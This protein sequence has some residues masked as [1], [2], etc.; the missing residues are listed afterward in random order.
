MLQ[1]AGALG[2]LGA[3]IKEYYDG[4]SDYNKTNYNVLPLGFG[5]GGEFGK[6]VAYVRVPRDET[7]RLVSGMLYQ[8]IMLAG[9]EGGP[10]GA[11]N[12]LA[13]GSGQ[14]PG[15]NP[16]LEIADGWKTYLEGQNP[17]DNF[18][19]SPVLTNAEWL[20]GGWPGAKAMLGWT[21]QNTGVTNFVRYD[22]DA[23]TGLEMAVSAAPGLNR[24]IQFSDAG[25]RERQQATESKESAAR[26]RL[27]LAMPANVQS[28]G[29]EYYHLRSVS[30]D[31]RTPQQT[32]RL[33]ELSRWHKS[34]YTDFEEAMSATGTTPGMLRSLE[35][36]SRPYERGQ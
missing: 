7:H 14:V 33:L 25:Y 30:P 27:R 35:D 9:G 29:S 18:R 2:L 16:I 12:L 22:E 24:F 20:A 13:F 31:L 28:L 15:L 8:T 4:I 34:I 32:I 17:R 36:L 23:N 5:E 3:A 26:A 19:G 1:A 10:K 21:A 6:R 11:S